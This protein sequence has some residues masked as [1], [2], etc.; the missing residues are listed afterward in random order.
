MLQT[1]Q[2]MSVEAQQPLGKPLLVVVGVVSFPEQVAQE[3]MVAVVLIT[4][5]PKVL[6]E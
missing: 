6:V 3:R 1:I 2:A 5:H 4:H